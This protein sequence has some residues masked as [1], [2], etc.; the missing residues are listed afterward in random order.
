MRHSIRVPDSMRSLEQTLDGKLIPFFASASN[1][2]FIKHGSVERC[3]IARVCWFCGKPLKRHRNDAVAF[4]MTALGA[5][6]GISLEPPQHPEC[7]QCLARSDPSLLLPTY[8]PPATVCDEKSLNSVLNNLAVIV[9]TTH[10]WNRVEKNS[11]RYFQLGYPVQLDFFQCGRMLTK[12][13]A[14]MCCGKLKD[15][16]LEWLISSANEK[17]IRKLEHRATIVQMTINQPQLM[18]HRWRWE[19]IAECVH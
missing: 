3:I 14:M 15:L 4:A 11:M 5:V 1:R 13:G 2:H 7:A 18:R 6:L 16:M 19:D 12:E 9:W 17:A 10:H 8:T